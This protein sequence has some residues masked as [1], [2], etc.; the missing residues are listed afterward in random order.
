MQ[1]ALLL[2]SERVDLSKCRGRESTRGA[3]RGRREPLVASAVGWC[4]DACSG[5]PGLQPLG[6]YTGL[7]SAL[8]IGRGGS[9]RC[10]SVSRQN[11]VYP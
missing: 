8:L 4:C 10:N 5:R 11:T 2:A 6:N 7:H 3:G 1:F 9:C